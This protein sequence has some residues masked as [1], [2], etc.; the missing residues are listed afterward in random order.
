M[1]SPSHANTFPLETSKA[2]PKDARNLDVRRSVKSMSEYRERSV[3]D[4]NVAR[5]VQS[6]DLYWI[7]GNL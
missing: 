4:W 7:K 2:I 3:V 1:Q 6:Y 5:K